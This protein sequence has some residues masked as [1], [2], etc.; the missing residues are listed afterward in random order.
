[1]FFRTSLQFEIY[2]DNNNW[3]Q[4]AEIIN[5]YY[6]TLIQFTTYDAI[7]VEVLSKRCPKNLYERAVTNKTYE[8]LLSK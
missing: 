6:P 1:M 5:T 4:M 8:K 2:N 7:Q 3:I